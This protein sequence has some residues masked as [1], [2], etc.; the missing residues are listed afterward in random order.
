MCKHDHD[1]EIIRDG[2]IQAPNQSACVHAGNMRFK[3]SE[4]TVQKYG[5]LDE[6]LEKATRRRLAQFEETRLQMAK[7]VLPSQLFKE[8]GR[9]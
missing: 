4:G 8:I 3:T 9:A 1:M 7:V 5:S 6:I 2:G